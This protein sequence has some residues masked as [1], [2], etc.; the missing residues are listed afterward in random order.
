MAGAVSMPTAFLC[1]TSLRASPFTFQ[2]LK[3]F[4]VSRLMFKVKWFDGQRI[5]TDAKFCVC[6]IIG[7]GA[8]RCADLQLFVPD[9]M[10]CAG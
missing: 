8:M 7:S 9:A 10:H 6:T 3:P 2:C 1:L 4:L 5:C